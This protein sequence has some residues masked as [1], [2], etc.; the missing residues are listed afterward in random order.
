MAKRLESLELTT[1][2]TA[3]EEVSVEVFRPVLA[4]LIDDPVARELVSMGFP[5]GPA[6]DAVRTQDTVNIMLEYTVLSLDLLL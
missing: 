2:S 3:A 1:L 6:Q 4:V 5:R